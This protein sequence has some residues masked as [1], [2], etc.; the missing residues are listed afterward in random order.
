MYNLIKK[1]VLIKEDNILNDN[2]FLLVL[3]YIRT[4]KGMLVDV[5][6]LVGKLLLKLFR[7]LC[8]GFQT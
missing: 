1:P 2:V 4:S 7:L 5:K 8:L 6:I 3:K